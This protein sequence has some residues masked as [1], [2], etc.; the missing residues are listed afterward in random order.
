MDVRRRSPWLGIGPS[1]AIWAIG[2]LVLGLWNVWADWASYFP[3]HPPHL[4]ID[5]TTTVI[6]TLALLFR[7]RAPVAVVLVVGLAQFLPDLF[8]P[9]GPAFWGEWV[10]LLVASYSLAASQVAAIDRRV[11]TI[12]V[13]LATCSYLVLSW[14]YPAEFW[15]PAATLT[16]VGPTVL[17]VAA[18]LGIGRLR[19][20]SVQL[21]RRA[22]DAETRQ[23]QEAE[24]AVER[25]R[26][27][28][29]RELHDVIAHS[30]SVMVVQ[31]S[32]AENV[33]DT[34]PAG[35]RAALGH[36]Q[37]AGR[38][39]LEEMRLLLGVLHQDGEAGGRAPVPSLSRLDA[40]VEPVRRSGLQVELEVRGIEDRLPPS[41]DVAAYRVVQEALT[42]A[43]RYAPDAQVRVLVDIQPAAVQVEVH[44]D[45][46]GG[47][48]TAGTGHGLLGLRERISLHGGTLHAG[49]APEGGFTVR[50]Q[51]PR[52]GVVAP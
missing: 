14:R 25:E 47:V 44:D 19:H 37:A 16:W 35:A 21:E 1:D 48:R 22:E 51:V 12:P 50:A 10:S 27:R 43:L 7:R 45:G 30:V 34:D 13:V 20:S 42:N 41:V 52:A 2:L 4:A 15:H 24:R 31:A 49:P 3:E 29:A 9:T 40:L 26:T 6:A 39:A 38:E 23:Q 11:V 46:T 36:V 18:G 32:A 28:I 5:T 33:L 17:A 8:V